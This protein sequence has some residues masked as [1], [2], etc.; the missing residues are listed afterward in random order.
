[1][2][3]SI[4]RSDLWNCLGQCQKVRQAFFFFC[5]NFGKEAKS[6]LLMILITSLQTVHK[7]K[8]NVAD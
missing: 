7:K 4:S 3:F 8:P 6:S 2:S 1:M 5:S